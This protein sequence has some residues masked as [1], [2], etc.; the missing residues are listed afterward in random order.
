MQGKRRSGKRARRL[1]VVVRRSPLGPS[2]AIVRMGNLVFPAAL[3]RAGLTV[4]KRE[5]DGAT[6]RAAMRLLS[7][8][9]RADRLFRPPSRLAI[10]AIRPSMGWC[11]APRHAR[12]NRPVRLPF[13]SS[14]ETLARADGLYDICL[15]MDWNLRCRR[16]N[17]GSAIFLHVAGPGFRPTEGC[18]AVARGALLQIAAHA[19]PGTVVHVE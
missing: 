12:Y 17:S 9:Y 2:R 5:G 19:G 1:P 6:P 15:V 10:A 8:F 13:A 16:K 4:R 14:H 7:G 3:G 11:D 18:V